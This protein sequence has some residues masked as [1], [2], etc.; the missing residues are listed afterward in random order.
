MG[1]IGT[2]G[3]VPFMCADGF[4]MTFHAM[5][6]T[7]SERF[8]EHQVIGGTPVLEWVG[9]ELH[10][11]RMNI[12]LDSSLGVSP[13]LVVKMLK[14]MMESASPRVLII[15]GEYL[16]K[17]VIESIHEDRRRFTGIGI[18]QVSEIGLEMKEVS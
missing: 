8:A 16:G 14:T 18:C 2:L 6:R 11:V 4:V 1:V 7:M 17:F 10:T 13:S 9:R 12:R 3:T 15:G 5:T